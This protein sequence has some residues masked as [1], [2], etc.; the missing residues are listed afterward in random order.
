MKGKNFFN[1]VLDFEYNM[2]GLLKEKITFFIDIPI[3]ISLDIVKSR[4]EKDVHE[5]DEEFLRKC[6]ENCKY[7]AEKYNLVHI[8]CFSNGKLL[9]V[10]EINDC[11]YEY[12]LKI[13]NFGV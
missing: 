2:C 5:E 7:I 12:V 4:G 1:W 11:I 10:E 9:S 8:N 6:Y 13:L 3:N